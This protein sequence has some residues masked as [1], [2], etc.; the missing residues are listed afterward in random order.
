[1]IGRVPTKNWW[2]LSI[3]MKGKTAVKTRKNWGSIILK[4]RPWKHLLIKNLFEPLHQV[5][6]QFYHLFLPGG[7]YGSVLSVILNRVMTKG[8]VAPVNLGKEE[9][10]GQ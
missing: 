1:V 7:Q 3:L 4:G 6:H 8:G 2:N 10:G 9:R 5:Y